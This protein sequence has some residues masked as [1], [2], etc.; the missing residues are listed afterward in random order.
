MQRLGLRYFDLKLDF[1]TWIQTILSN[2]NE[3]TFGN[4]ALVKPTFN[5]SENRLTFCT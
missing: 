1:V 4:F 3:L 2:K 5:N